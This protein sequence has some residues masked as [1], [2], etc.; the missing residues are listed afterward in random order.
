M[1]NIVTAYLLLVTS[2]IYAQYYLES[3]QWVYNLP[4]SGECVKLTIAGDTTINDT[5][6][7][8]V[9]IS[10]CNTNDSIS[11]EYIYGTNDKIYWYNSTLDHFYTLYDFSAQADDIINS[12]LPPTTLTNPY[13][14]EDSLEYSYSVISNSTITLE[15]KVLNTQKIRRIGE[16]ELYDWTLDFNE[17]TEI[18]II[19]K[20]GSLTYYF[21]RIGTAT[22]EESLG[23]L[24]CY[25]DGQINY[26]ADGYSSNNCELVSSLEINSK[27]EIN[28][29]P[30]P[31]KNVINISKTENALYIIY[32][33][34]GNPLIN[35]VNNKVDI[36]DL[37]KG[38][39]IL[40]IF[41]GEKLVHTQKIQKN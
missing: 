27:I 8:H 4:E 20:V 40:K 41:N 5:I 13:F 9:L 6:A 38:L 37:Q 28:V 30:N 11:S 14:N 25:T 17:N 15:D 26:Y 19:E 33:L 24:R 29:Y 23:H 31:S 18:S 2:I 36:S 1:K 21:G 12:Y 39:Y 22:Y 7:Q 3:T 32:D 35:T 10:S 16:I 34:L